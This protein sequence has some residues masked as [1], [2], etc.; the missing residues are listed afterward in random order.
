[1]NS[2]QI[3]AKK[4]RGSSFA[5]AKTLR[6]VIKTLNA[7]SLNVD[8]KAHPSAAVTVDSVPEVKVSLFKNLFRARNDVYAVSGIALPVIDGLLAATA[9]DHNLML[10]TRDTGQIPTMGVT[11]FNPWQSN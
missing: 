8:V 9:L 1:M 2:D 11:V 3:C 7:P 6:S 5:L 10:V 4:T